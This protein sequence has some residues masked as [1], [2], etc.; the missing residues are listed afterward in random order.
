M[1]D[2]LGVYDSLSIAKR[3][4]KKL[5][6]KNH[7]YW[8]GTI[9]FCEWNTIL[10]EIEY[11]TEAQKKLFKTPYNVYETT[12]PRQKPILNAEW[13]WQFSTWLSTIKD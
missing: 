5:I 13:K 6:N 12:E 2:L 7:K 3:Q 8:D 4:S 11:E 10:E 9:Q 1:N